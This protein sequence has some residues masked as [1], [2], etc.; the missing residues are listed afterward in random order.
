MQNGCPV[1]LS[2]L[3]KL[4]YCE[5]DG[6]CCCH[7]AVFYDQAGLGDCEAGGN[8]CCKRVVIFN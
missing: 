5:V 4:E 2:Y 8:C 7:G 6:N 1:F 3:A